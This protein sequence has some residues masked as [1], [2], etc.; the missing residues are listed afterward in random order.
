MYTTNHAY[1]YVSTL[2]NTLQLIDWPL[3]YHGGGSCVF[4]LIPGGQ[5]TPW[6]TRAQVL[7]LAGARMCS[8]LRRDN[9]ACD[10][11]IHRFATTS[12][13]VCSNQCSYQ[14]LRFLVS[15]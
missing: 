5:R 9:L 4:S 15:V 7:R 14:F 2:E 11:T 8:T 1:L 12:E 10:N 13:S 3:R 6:W